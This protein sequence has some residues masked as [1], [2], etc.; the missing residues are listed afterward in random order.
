MTD[1]RH[2]KQTRTEGIH[3]IIAYAYADS[4]A[5]L[6]AIG[7]TPAD[8]GKVAVDLDTNDLSWLVDDSPITWAT[9]DAGVA[10]QLNKVRIDCRKATAGT[11]PKGKVVYAT[12][13][14]QVGEYATVELAQSNSTSTMPAVG[15]IEEQ[16]S[17]SVTGKVMLVGV[18]ELGDTSSY[19]QG[20][21]I[22]VS[23]ATAGDFTQT[24]PSGPN[25][26]QALGI[27]LDSDVSNGHLGVNVLGYR[28]Y[29]Y[30]SDPQA[31]G[32]AS[33][34]TSNLAS[35]ADHVHP[36]ELVDQAQIY[37]VGKHGNDSNSGKTLN[38]AFL[39][40]GAAI[41]EAQSQVPSSSNPFV[42]W[43]PDAGIY[44]EDITCQSY[45]NIIAPSAFIIGEVILADYSGFTVF[46]VQVST[47]KTAVK[48]TSGTESSSLVCKVIQCAGTSNAIFNDG[49]DSIVVADVDVI[50]VVDGIA[51]HDSSSGS[52]NTHA[53]V[54]DINI[55]GN[56]KGLVTSGGSGS[57]FFD[58]DEIVDIGAG[59]TKGIE[60]QTG[61]ARGMVRN[62]VADTAWDVSSGASLEAFVCNYSG[63][64]VETGTVQVSVSG[65]AVPLSDTVP[66]N[67]TKAAS[68]AG[69]A[70]ESSRQDHKHDVTTAAPGTTGVA[71]A[72]AEGSA[73]SLAR[74]D[75][76][77]QSNTAPVA[78]TK[79]A[80]VIGT[81]GEPARADHKHDVSTAAAGA[82]TPGDSAAEGAATS[83]ARSDHQHSIAAFG[84]SAGTF[85][86]GNDSRLSDAR[87]PT[88]TA[89]GDLGGT[90]PSPTVNDGADS[91][92]IH[93][94]VAA[95][96]SAITEKTSPVSADLAIIED[97]QD[98]NNKKKVQLGNILPSAFQA[99][100]TANT[101][102]TSTTPT[103]INAMTLTPGAGNYVAIF[104][105]SGKTQAG[106]DAVQI[107]I[108]SNGGAVAHSERLKESDTVSMI[109]TQAYITGLGAG[110]AIDVRGWNTAGGKT[111]TI[112]ER[113]LVLVKV[114]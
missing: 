47:G 7:F 91:T 72:S 14:N 24:A 51:V 63:S 70:T 104:S 114:A 3:T 23:A 10:A 112:Y 52:G 42:I 74:S 78:V 81:S 39:T 59:T 57:L 38:D 75:H 20:L 17:D 93:D 56:G 88:G 71:T 87:T 108:Y 62:L 97:S 110:Q 69:T 33:A 95:E 22:Y 89:S 58:I 49:S 66:V 41:T 11:I 98:S 31:P 113:S 16:C 34:G 111:T 79:A 27:V 73:T 13:Y 44:T 94:N 5:R 29:D 2:S 6:A 43:C 76:A 103:V 28:A 83:L 105:C 106:G 67:V 107:S 86:E 53:R 32:T 48:K 54:G 15:I 99:T 30:V 9:F 8:V 100:A 90:Y 84:S 45:V 101:T 109:S 80:A 65:D 61:N 92:A 26:T 77:H 102:I 55:S 64:T 18:L 12:G 46:W 37:Y 36:K 1:A 4:T 40:F 60:V 96:I 50:N 25:I 19:T 68:S 35:P 21:P 85:C 82:T